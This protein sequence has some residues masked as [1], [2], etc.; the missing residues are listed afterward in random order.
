[1]TVSESVVAPDE[2]EGI[3]FMHRTYVRAFFLTAYL[4]I[5]LC[6]VIGKTLLNMATNCQ[7]Y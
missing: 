5:F 1:M 4:L 2:D 7:L 3:G 6:C